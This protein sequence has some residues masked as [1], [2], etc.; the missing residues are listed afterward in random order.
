VIRPTV[1]YD[2][3]TTWPLTEKMGKLLM[4]WERKV[5]REIYGPTKENGCWRIKMNHEI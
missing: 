4:A 3:E 1:T 2:V 5:L